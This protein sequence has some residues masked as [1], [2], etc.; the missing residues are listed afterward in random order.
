MNLVGIKHGNNVVIVNKDNYHDIDS[1]ARNTKAAT[2]IGS[3][4]LSNVSNFLDQFGNI[5]DRG[6]NYD[7]KNVVADSKQ[8]CKAKEAG[9][10][11]NYKELIQYGL[12]NHIQDGVAC[13]VENLGGIEILD[14]LFGLN[15][16]KQFNFDKA[17]EVD[18][19][20]QAIKSS[21]LTAQKQQE[22]N[23]LAE[24]FR[25]NEIEAINQNHAQQE[26]LQAAMKES[27]ILEQAIQASLESEYRVAVDHIIA[28]PGGATVIQ[29][30]H[31]EVIGQEEKDF[32]D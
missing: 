30:L 22:D 5:S 13:P 4:I 9:F 12:A 3:S 15:L 8:F 31:I 1:I 26:Q 16:A 2:M 18:E 24:A 25:L 21:K 27:L 20:T 17:S 11:V 10:V 6:F 28:P 14:A 23:D 19:L 7:Q 29:E 32:S